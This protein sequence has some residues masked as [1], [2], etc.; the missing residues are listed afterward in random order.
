MGRAG[1]DC[2]LFPLYIPFTA[3][4]NIP[5]KEG[6]CMNAILFD[7]NYQEPFVFLTMADDFLD[8]E[9]GQESAARDLFERA[10]T[11]YRKQYR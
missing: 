11:Y 10:F 7:T 5:M 1:T 2:I 8:A 4:Y 9:A 3:C 6:D